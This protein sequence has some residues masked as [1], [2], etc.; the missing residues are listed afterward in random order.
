MGRVSTTNPPP[1]LSDPAPHG[2][3]LREE[4]GYASWVA[5]PEDPGREKSLPAVF[6][7][8]TNKLPATDSLCGLGIKVASLWPL[9]SS[10]R[11]VIGLDKL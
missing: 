11:Q 4:K 10:I 7:L 2:L 5:P 6:V 8:L 9:V 3:E 1:Y